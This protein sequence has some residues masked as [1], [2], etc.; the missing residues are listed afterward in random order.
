L[1]KEGHLDLFIGFVHGKELFCQTGY[2][3]G[4]SS[5]ER[6]VRGAEAEKTTS[7]VKWSRAKRA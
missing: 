1:G 3:K 2:Q 5:I 4:S 7:L 6:A